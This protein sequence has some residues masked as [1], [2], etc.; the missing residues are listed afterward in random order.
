ML[1]GKMTLIIV[2]RTVSMIAKRG[3]R[4]GGFPLV[5][6]SSRFRSAC[7]VN[8]FLMPG[9]IIAF[10]KRRAGALVRYPRSDRNGVCRQ[11]RHA[12]SP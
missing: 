6:V 2:R 9:M 12:P 7:R 10:Q 5:T 8:G 11:I 4:A 1:T 3:N